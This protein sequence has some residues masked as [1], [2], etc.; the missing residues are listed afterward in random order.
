MAE[1][2]NMMKLTGT[3][4]EVVVAYVDMER[5][6]KFYRLTIAIQRLS[7]IVDVIPV[8]CSEKLLYDVD[9]TP[10]SV[11][12]VNGYI[13]TRN[14]T[15]TEGHNHLEVFGY[16]YRID[17]IL[18]GEK[19][20]TKE[21]NVIK[22]TGFICRPVRKRK[23]LKTQREITDMVVAVE[24]PYARRDYIPCI[25]W[26]RNAILAGNRTVGD[27]VQVT[28]RFQSRQ[29]KKKD[30]DTLHN[31]YEVSVIDLQVLEQ[32]PPKEEPVQEEPADPIKEETAQQE[33]EQAA[34]NVTAT[35]EIVQDDG[36][37]KDVLKDE[38]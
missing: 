23:T 16:V 30:D 27:K 12:T 36:T 21:N 24:R 14:F 2:N 10:G 29:Y 18:E 35:A 28:G 19:V 22:I 5:N 13:R 3:V 7:D 17:N 32:A 37:I 4:Q 38:Q 31:T 11:I 15:D 1:N 9:C 8:I 25:A 6:E 34:A 33:Q 26:S 20:D